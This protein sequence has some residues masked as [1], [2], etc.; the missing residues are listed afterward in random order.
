V[1]PGTLDEL[2]D[3]RAACTGA[4]AT[5]VSTGPSRIVVVGAGDLDHDVDESAGGTLAAFGADVRAGGDDLVL[6]LSLTI[7]AWL[8]DAAGW[9]G[10]RT[11]STGHPQVDAGE[12]LLVMADGSATRSDKAPGFFD[13][14]AETFDAAIASALS[15]GDA[16][17]LMALDAGLGAALG[18]TGVPAL[19]VLGELTKGAS[20]A[21]HLRYD[22]APFGVGYLV[23]DWVLTG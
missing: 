21:A 1:A 12:A 16:D 19:H 15:S 4:V 5:L 6:P 20:V 2:G 8:L 23:A 3:V 7:G 17:A 22:G 13:E 10:P 18:S 11:Y 14:R 9:A